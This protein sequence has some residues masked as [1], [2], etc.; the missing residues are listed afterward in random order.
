MQSKYPGTTVPK[1]SSFVP[2]DNLDDV[3]EVHNNWHAV[4][5]PIQSHQQDFIAYAYAD[6]HFLHTW[7]VDE[8]TAWF[9]DHSEAVQFA[10]LFG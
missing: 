5:W 7:T 2:Y 10:L 8:H 9:E 1:H 4:H 6:D 3:Y